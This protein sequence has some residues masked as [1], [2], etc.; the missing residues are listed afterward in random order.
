[1]QVGS[2]V[3]YK[4]RGYVGTIVRRCYK[5]NKH[6]DWMVLWDGQRK[7]NP[8]EAWECN[9]E[10]LDGT[11]KAE[12]GRLARPQQQPPNERTG[13]SLNFAAED[14][15][16]HRTNHRCPLPSVFMSVLAG[17]D[18][19][20]DSSPVPLRPVAQPPQVHIGAQYSQDAQRV[21]QPVLFVKLRPDVGHDVDL[22]EQRR[23]GW[24]DPAPR[25]HGSWSSHSGITLLA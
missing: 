11:A 24:F 8:A 17:P 18:H 15:P 19:P 22:H 12:Q 23:L 25:V 7:Y 13:G 20:H 4:P 1:M 21:F 5:H 3:R 9:L 10:E 6:G 16:E 2:R 14:R